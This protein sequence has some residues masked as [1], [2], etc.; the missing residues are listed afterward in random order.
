MHVRGNLHAWRK[1]E[2]EEGMKGGG[3]KDKEG[4]RSVRM[5]E[6]GS[7]LGDGREKERGGRKG[8]KREGRERRQREKSKIRGSRKE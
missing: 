4:K 6:V 3:G 5:R 1:V 7:C 2:E 8:K